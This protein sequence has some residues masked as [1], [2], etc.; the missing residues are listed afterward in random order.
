MV[1]GGLVGMCMCVWPAQGL[2]NFIVA[3]IDM[4]FIFLAGLQVRAEVAEMRA[5]LQ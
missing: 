3:L 1:V 2:Y 5:K 4:V